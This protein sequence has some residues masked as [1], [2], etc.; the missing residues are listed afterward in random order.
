MAAE[1]TP[2]TRPDEP[3]PLRVPCV[4]IIVAAPAWIST[5]LGVIAG[6]GLLPAL[7]GLVVGCVTRGGSA[8]AVAW[9]IP[10]VAALGLR[11]LVFARGQLGA[12][13]AM[14]E[15]GELVLSGASHTIRV[16]LRAITRGARSPEDFAVHLDLRGGSR[17][18]MMPTEDEDTPR[19]LAATGVGVDR[20]A[21]VVPLR[22]P[23]GPVV[24]GLLY[25]GFGLLGGTAL[26]IA[27]ARSDGDGEDGWRAL[28]V[29]MGALIFAI[30]MVRA[31]RPRLVIGID[32]L[33]VKRGFRSRFIPYDEIVD[34]AASVSARGPALSVNRRARAP[35]EIPLAGMPPAAVAQL[36]ARIEDAIAAREGSG[37]IDVEAFARRGRSLAAWRED[38]RRLL[39]AEGG[40]RSVRVTSPDAEA[41]LADPRAPVEARVGAVLA[42][43]AFG[44]ERVRERVRVAVAASADAA[45]GRAL[46]AACDDEDAEL[47]D[48][49]ASH[50]SAGRGV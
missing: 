30:A 46:D 7:A 21:Y 25:V 3:G 36:E 24:A 19:L 35:V 17:V 6:L 10:C 23:V 40:Y 11:Q 39:A 38:L 33:L 29:S 47:E 43:R 45:A 37:R 49:L 31:R 1:S 2:A 8:S 12:G 42:L 4:R 26:G 48:A 13:E 20:R 28:F 14:V 5:L 22:G 15:A 50:P 27:L 9:A 44:A 41:V 18:V 16:P 32:G 34:I